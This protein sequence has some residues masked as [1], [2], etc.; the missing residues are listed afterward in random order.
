MGGGQEQQWPRGGGANGSSKDGEKGLA[1][2]LADIKKQLAQLQ[3]T[4]TTKQPQP[5]AAADEEDPE[6]KALEDARQSLETFRKVAQSKSSSE[7]A[8]KF[9]NEEIARLQEKITQA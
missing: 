8:K 4:T 1:K 9:A 3:S 5:A 7:A 2:Q 6:A